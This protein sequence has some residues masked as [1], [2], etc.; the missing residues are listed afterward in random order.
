MT[1][2]QWQNE[3][4]SAGNGAAAGADEEELLV[5]DIETTRNEMSGTISEI[6]NR[7]SP[8][9]ITAETKA[10]VRDATVGRF[11]DFKR[12]AGQTMEQTRTGIVDTIRSNPVPAAIAAL[13]V[14][15]LVKRYREQES[16]RMPTRREAWSA[17]RGNGRYA[18]IYAADYLGSAGNGDANGGGGIVQGAQE[19]L[20][21]AVQGVTGTIGDTAARAGQVTSEIGR[22]AQ[23][24]LRNAESGLGQGIESVRGQT[25]T[26]T[27]QARDLFDRTLQENPLALGALAVAAG[28]A[29]GMVIQETRKEREL[30]AQPREQV[31][32][33]A[34]ARVS[35][36]LDQATSKAQEMSEQLTS[37]GGGNS[38]GDAATAG[39]DAASGS[40][41]PS[42]SSSGSSGSPGSSGARSASS[43]RSSSGTGSQ[44]TS[45]AR[46][47]TGSG[48][49]ATGAIASEGLG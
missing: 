49:G 30:Y 44:T 7:L 47:S 39:G 37:D 19:R 9:T 20:G 10:R 43:R 4:A 25:S 29:A 3:Q 40:S 6:G 5:A 12:E 21:D 41:G 35:D 11:E 24:A 27:W 22:T 13:G 17:P 36:V 42:A 18:D 31:M 15:W 46:T 32:Q 2:G 14:G 45:M 23:D 33:A 28:A 26:A 48:T 34:A 8:E 16:E 1:N 38:S